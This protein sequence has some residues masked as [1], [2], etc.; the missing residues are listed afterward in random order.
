[1][2]ALLLAVALSSCA[3]HLDRVAASAASTSAPAPA[4][5]PSAS[6]AVDSPAEDDEADDPAGN[7]Q[8]PGPFTLL[9][10]SAE[11]AIDGD[12]IVV[13]HDGRSDRLQLTGSAVEASGVENARLLSATRSN[14]TTYALLRLD[15][16]SR[17]VPQGGYCG[18]GLEST[19][20]LLAIE[21]T[22]VLVLDQ[23]LLES[24]VHNIVAEPAAWH[25]DRLSFARQMYGEEATTSNCIVYDR[26]HPASPPRQEPRCP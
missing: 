18:G 7:W 1:M 13:E 24:C 20:V 11:L 14:L 4:P 16:Y 23:Q 9:A 25:G 2:R 5:A 3:S 10:V 26:R 15:P 6:V 22:R 8:D 12:R 21:P 19:L 17:Q